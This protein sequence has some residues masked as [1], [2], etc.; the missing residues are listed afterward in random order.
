MFLSESTCP[1]YMTRKQSIPCSGMYASCGWGQQDKR[2]RIVNPDT[3]KGAFFKEIVMSAFARF[4]KARITTPYFVFCSW[5]RFFACGDMMLHPILDI[6]SLNVVLS[7]SGKTWS[8]VSSNIF[9]SIVLGIY[10][11]VFGFIAL[12][13]KQ[14][15]YLGE[16]CMSLFNPIEYRLLMIFSTLF[17]SWGYHRTL[18]REVDQCQSVGRRHRRR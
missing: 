7:L 10:V 15:W 12:K 18:R 13:I 1:Q 9:W 8:T 3:K 4:T 16:A 2:P 14:K 11:L 17:H 6:S 5:H